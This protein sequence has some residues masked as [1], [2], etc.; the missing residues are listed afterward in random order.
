M[1]NKNAGD[2]FRRRHCAL[3]RGIHSVSN[4]R[5]GLH[6]RPSIHFQGMR[7]LSIGLPFLR[8]TR[9]WNIGI[10]AHLQRIGPRCQISGSFQGPKGP[11]R[12]PMPFFGMAFPVILPHVVV[13]SRG[14]LP[15]A[16]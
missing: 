12:L 3:V 8:V 16:I 4:Q 2:I 6:D 15:L 7:P 11:F 9:L 13:E 14:G 5:L 10:P 1:V